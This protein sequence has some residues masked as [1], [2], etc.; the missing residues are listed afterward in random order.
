[1]TQSIQNQVI[2]SL[3]VRE[4]ISWD[5]S[6]NI[7]EARLVR[8]YHSKWILWAKITHLATMWIILIVIF[9][10]H[11]WCYFLISSIIH[12][13]AKSSMIFIQFFTHHSYH[14]HHHHHH[15][16]RSN[17]LIIMMMMYQMWILFPLPHVST[18]FYLYC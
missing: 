1:M 10:K 2:P 4:R 16:F 18:Q 8:F 5:E 11:K 15:C 7:H 3:V 6:E 13:C 17:R 14:H 9:F 12:T